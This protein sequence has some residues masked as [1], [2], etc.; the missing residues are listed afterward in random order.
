M[1]RR[2]NKQSGRAAAASLEPVS[3]SGNP[4]SRV[5]EPY[6]SVPS[7]V[8]DWR[9]LHLAAR[10]GDLGRV[11][12]ILDRRIDAGEISNREGRVTRSTLLAAGASCVLASNRVTAEQSEFVNSRDPSGKSA[13]HEACA[14]GHAEISRLLLS[15]GALPAARKANGFTPLLCAAAGGHAECA[16]LLL[17]HIQAGERRGPSGGEGTGGSWGSGRMSGWRAADRCGENALH[18]AARAG[19]EEVVAMLVDAGEREER[20]AGDQEQRII[21]TEPR[22]QQMDLR[23]VEGGSLME[24]AEQSGERLEDREMQEG[25]GGIVSPTRPATRGMDVECRFVN[26]RTRN[27]RTPLHSSCLHGHVAVCDFLLKHGANRTARDSSGSEPIHEAAAGGHV[28]VIDLLTGVVDQAHRVDVKSRDASGATPM[29]R[30]AAAGH[31]DAMRALS[32]HGA[33]LETVDNAGTTPLY[34][35]ASRG[36][37]AAVEWLLEQQEQE[38]QKQ[39]QKGRA[40]GGGGG[41][42]YGKER[43]SSSEERSSSSEERSSSSEERSSSSKERSSREG[44]GRSRRSALHVAAG[45]GHV[46]VCS[47]LLAWGDLIPWDGMQMGQRLLIWPNGCLIGP[48]ERSWSR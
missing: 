34:W 41:G 32:Q 2:R 48:K 46:G 10:D 30:A 12:D 17:A 33:E 7:N 39:V 31:V 16:Q 1:G 15:L 19:A 28:A 35:A 43:S 40:G 24:G 18:L 4:I 45:W 26:A 9:L 3:G 38:D 44:G 13:L 47:V 37:V 25:R 14:H 5:R 27:G 21:D 6:V 8:A 23:Q 29:H 36:H 42:R 20:E 11:Q 22:Q